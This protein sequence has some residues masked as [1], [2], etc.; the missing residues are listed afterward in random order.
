MS[1][2]SRTFRNWSATY[3][4]SSVAEEPGP[5][6]IYQKG[7]SSFSEPVAGNTTILSE[8]FRPDLATRSSNTSDRPHKTF[9]FVPAVT[10]LTSQGSSEIDFDFSASV[11]KFWPDWAKAKNIRLKRN[12][13]V[14]S[15]CSDPFE[16]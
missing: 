8:S 6:G 2:R 9:S 5:P 11:K 3:G 16:R 7:S 12:V 10:P 13:R 15:I 4:A 1:R 14:L